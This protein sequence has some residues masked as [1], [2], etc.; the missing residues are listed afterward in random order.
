MINKRDFILRSSNFCEKY[1]V[2]LVWS[3]QK[4]LLESIARAHYDK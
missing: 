1:V 3:Q 2:V 4:Q